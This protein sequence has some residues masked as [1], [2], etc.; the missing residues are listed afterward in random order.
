MLCI[1]PSAITSYYAVCEEGTIGKLRGVFA[2]ILMRCFCV[3]T[4]VPYLHNRDISIL[5]NGHPSLLILAPSAVLKQAWG[6]IA[7]CHP[8][9]RT[10]SV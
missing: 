1:D 10:V 7:N 2:Y 5:M 4:S 9:I 6:K 3:H 8:T